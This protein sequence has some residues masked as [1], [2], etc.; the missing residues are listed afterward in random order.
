MAK[1]KKGKK[2][3]KNKMARMTEE[4]K[5]LYL[6]QKALEEEDMRKNKEEMLVQFLKV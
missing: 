2:G 6:E 5:I 1:K 4:E 3:K